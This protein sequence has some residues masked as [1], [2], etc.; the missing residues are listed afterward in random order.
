MGSQ[1]TIAN[2]KLR[3]FLRNKVHSFNKLAD[4]QGEKGNPASTKV[5]KTLIYSQQEAS[6]Q[7]NL[8]QH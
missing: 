1:I 5:R 8:T 4:L 3:Q 6:R 7:L 2:C